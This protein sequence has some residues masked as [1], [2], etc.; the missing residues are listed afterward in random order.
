MARDPVQAT[1]VGPMVVSAVEQYEPADRRVDDDPLAAYMVSP[2]VRVAVA[3]CRVPAVRRAMLNASERSVPGAWGSLVCRKRYAD[4]QVDDALRNGI[5]QVVLLGAGFDT[6]SV[7]LVSPRGAAA[8]EVDLPGNV[9]AKR[10]RL[11]GTFGRVPDRVQLVSVDFE[12]DD[13]VE[14]LTT[15]GFDA[16]APAMVVWEAVTQYLTVGAVRSMLKSLSGV[17]RDS[18]LIFTYV[19]KDLING[20]DLHGADKLYQRYV[21]KDQTWL[22]GLDQ[23]ELGS[24]LGPYGWAVIEDV[25][26]AEYIHRYL[27]PAGRELP[28]MA[29]ERFVRA[30][31]IS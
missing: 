23:T 12:R 15:V 26:P 8:Y 20:S 22:F 4:D 21:I 1:A 30:T 16:S 14:A 31:K 2:A 6:R 29:I 9:A 27:R 3:S 13:P 18:R 5:K 28:V 10:K 17:A 24:L 19:L 25:G 7:R 11:V